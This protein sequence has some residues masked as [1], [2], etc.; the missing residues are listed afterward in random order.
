MTGKTHFAVGEAATL[1]L[2]Q[3]A[4]PKDLILYMGVA[5]VGSLICDVDSTTSKSHKA[6]TTLSIT[7]VLALGVT[8]ALE[9]EYQVGIWAMLRRQTDLF[10][11]VTCLALMLVV[12]NYGMHQ[13]H[14]SFMHSFLALGLLSLLVWQAFPPLLY[15]F[16]IS[17]SSHM[18]IDLLNRKGL[19]LFFPF[20]ASYCFKLCPASGQVNDMLYTCASIAMGVGVLLSLCRIFL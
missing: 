15:P 12:C 16:L 5:S 14:R 3:P 11:I 17:M 7:A 19:V 9:L 1:L 4:T 2:L 13:P 8:V 10:H 6:L 18:A 20:P